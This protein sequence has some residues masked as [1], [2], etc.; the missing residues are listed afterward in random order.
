MSCADPAA[1]ATLAAREILKFVRDGGRFRDVAVLVR[2][3]NGYQKPLERAFRRYD[4]PFFLDRREGVAHHPLAELTR[5]A[6]RT[7]TFDWQHEDWFAALKAGFAPVEET[8]IDRLENEALA[9]GWRGAKWRQPLA[10]AGDAALAEFVEQLRQKLLPPFEKLA[11][12]LESWGKRPTGAQLAEA[13]RQFWTRVGVERTLERWAEDV[14][15]SSEFRVPSSVH[16]TVL[17]QMHAWLDNLALAFPREALPLRDWLPVI[18]AGL[19]NLTVGVIPPALDQVLIGAID[20]ARNPDLRLAFVL[21][22]NEG[23]FPA[24]PSAPLIL[25]DAD[26]DELGGRGV[27]LGP[28]LRERLARERYFGYIACTRSSERLVLTWAE[29]DAAGKQLNTS[30]FLSH[31]RRM[32]PDL[33]VEEFRGEPDLRAAEHICELIAPLVAER[34]APARRE[35]DKQVQRAEL[36]LRAPASAWPTL[37]QL[38]TLAVLQ[39]N[40][41]QL[42]NPDPKE[43]LAPE[44]AE[45]LYGLVLKT[46]VS[47][48]EN[49]A[50]C[51]FR[52]LVHSGLRAEERKVFELDSREQGSFQH[53]VL[54]I[55][56]EEL[57]AEE[58]L[59]RDLTPEVARARIWRIANR[60]MADYRDG[61][62]RDSPQ[63]QFTARVLTRALQ[64]FIGVLVGWM[65]TRYRFD[66]AAVE[67]DF[68][69]GGK[70]PAWRLELGGGRQLLLRGRIDRVDLF[71]EPG[72]DTALCVVIDYK[73]SEKKLDPLLLEH[74]VQLQLLSYLNVLQQR[75]APQA[76]GVKRLVPAGVFYVNLRGGYTSGSTRATL[77]GAAEA[78]KEAYRH[79]GRFD[80]GWLHQLDASGESRGEQFNF[81]LKQDGQLYANCAEALS[82]ADFGALLQRVETQL[83]EMGQR[84]FAGEAAVDPYRKG[85]ETP[86]RFC[87]YAQVCRIDPWTHQY[88]VLRKANSAEG[89]EAGSAAASPARP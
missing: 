36:E 88:R 26:R 45:K 33:E 57:Q 87:D 18:E 23:V 49:F 75:V 8:E 85:T 84:I 51:P 39:E 40:L 34:G 69:E 79:A 35:P 89:S 58:K 77:A 41:D 31:V 29:K 76:L 72:A 11:A 14:V 42:R 24:T 46:S 53:D 4:I 27:A 64:D 7:V 60:L 68:A 43:Q 83:R 47:R 6:L 38:P 78:R 1:E 16:G 5:S 63:T 25:S 65:H 73:S 81:R 70:V 66:P 62:L 21:G 12:Q 71:R 19:G 9:R 37:L 80:A 50:T 82:A 13:L 30:S 48:M 61:L 55:F 20:R 3:L 56:H 44:L 10:L 74:G 59:W 86:C 67:L 28:D 22:L 52:F 54:R 32:I 17:T 2:Q 15:S